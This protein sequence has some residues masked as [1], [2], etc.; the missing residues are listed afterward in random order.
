MVRS[1]G[2]ASGQLAGSARNSKLHLPTDR[3]NQT[4]QTHTSTSSRTASESQQVIPMP[5][6]A[7][8]SSKGNDGRALLE[9]LS[10]SQIYKDY[11]RAFAETTG[12]PLALS[13]TED[14]HLTHHNRRKE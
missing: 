13:P 1:D 8:R 11:E 10:E 7:P 3:M 14:L 2:W 12:L 4:I 9:R 5:E 6:Q